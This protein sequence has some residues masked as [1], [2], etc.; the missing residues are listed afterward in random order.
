MWKSMLMVVAVSVCVSCKQTS[1]QESS[2]AEKPA[3]LGEADLGA[4]YQYYHANPQTL[5][6]KDENKLIEFAAERNMALTR[7]QS[8]VYVQELRNGSGAPIK[9][10]DPIATHY[11][12]MFLDGKEFD[13]SIKRG[14]PLEF[15]VGQM[16]PGWNEAL[17][18]RSIGDKFVLLIPSHMG[19]GK[20]GFPGAVPPDANLIFE[21]EVL[22]DTPQ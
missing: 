21:V 16:I 10:G 20:R 14:K 4:L 7:T 13:S 12:G 15:R 11:R 19:Y 5:E 18:T 22:Y 3:S 8:G 1:T 2:A 17:I 6:Q 9:W